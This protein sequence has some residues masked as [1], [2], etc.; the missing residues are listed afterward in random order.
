MPHRKDDA[1]A[2]GSKISFILT[3]ISIS[4]GSAAIREGFSTLID[5][6]QRTTNLH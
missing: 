2:N 3:S 5:R 4:V 6:E 1:A